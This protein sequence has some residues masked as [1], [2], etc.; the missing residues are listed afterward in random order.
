[1]G[2]KNLFWL[3]FQSTRVHHG[4]KDMMTGGKHTTTGAVNFLIVLLTG[5]RGF[6]SQ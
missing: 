1:M 3:A 5:S 6:D 4:D 2:R